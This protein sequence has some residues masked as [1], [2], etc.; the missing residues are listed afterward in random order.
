M[1][2]VSIPG[3]SRH[4]AHRHRSAMPLSIPVANFSGASSPALPFCRKRLIASF[5]PA[6]YPNECKHLGDHIRRRRLDLGLLQ[7][8]VAARIGVREDSI[9]HCEVGDTAPALRWLPG[10]ITFLGYDPRPAPVGVGAR[11]RHC[12]EGRGL[13]QLGLART[14]GVDAGTLR[15]W[16]VGQRQPTGRHS[17]RVRR[18]LKGASQRPPTE[19]ETMPRAVLLSGK[20]PS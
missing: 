14:L 20:E 3:A 8:D 11:L 6:G 18:L 10:I 12:R 15:R 1:I 17:A 16:E 9:H 5:R 4:E 13:S 2:S 19:F 7:M